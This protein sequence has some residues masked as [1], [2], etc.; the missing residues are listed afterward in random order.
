MLL[1]SAHPITW[2]FKAV[3]SPLRTSRQPYEIR[4]HASG[5][6]VVK[7]LSKYKVAS[8]ATLETVFSG[9]IATHETAAAAGGGG[10][11]G[12]GNVNFSSRPNADIVNATESIFGAVTTFSQISHANRIRL[13]LSRPGTILLVVQLFFMQSNS[14]VLYRLFVQC[15]AISAN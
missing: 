6:S 14:K 10:G 8:N 2:R 7:V 15:D 11:G 13:E 1:D 5:S 9:W 3:L 12:S 4:I